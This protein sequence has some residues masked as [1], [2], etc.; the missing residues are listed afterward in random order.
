MNKKN[1]L[2]QVNVNYSSNT[3]G[4][5][6]IVPGSGKFVSKIDGKVGDNTSQQFVSVTDARRR[7]R[8][9]F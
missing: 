3:G 7:Y 1:L 4:A 6:E 9:R 5:Y 8:Y 2:K